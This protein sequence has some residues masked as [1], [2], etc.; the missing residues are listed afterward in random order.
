MT[1][2]SVYRVVLAAIQQGLA[3]Y[4][5]DFMSYDW[6]SDRGHC[7]LG[8]CAYLVKNLFSTSDGA[9]AGIKAT[10]PKA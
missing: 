4:G 1:H 6:S 7:R 9:F 2:T 3:G 10:A 5:V 8:R